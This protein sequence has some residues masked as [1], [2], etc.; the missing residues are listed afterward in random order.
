[1]Q[2]ERPPEAKDESKAAMSDIFFRYRPRYTQ[3]DQTYADVAIRSFRMWNRSEE[4]CREMY[5]GLHWLICD[6]CGWELPDALQTGASCHF[7]DWGRKSNFPSTVEKMVEVMEEH[8][9][10]CQQEAVDEYE[11]DPK[12]GKSYYTHHPAEV[13]PWGEDTL[14]MIRA[15]MNSST[16]ER[17][18]IHRTLKEVARDTAESNLFDYAIEAEP[19]SVE[20]AVRQEFERLMNIFVKTHEGESCEG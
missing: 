2:L 18:C 5:L 17:F 3:P 12:W 7:N 16:F 13:H 9:S 14:K 8:I 11:D 15:W 6:W 10:K 19:E 20:N 1:M 4:R